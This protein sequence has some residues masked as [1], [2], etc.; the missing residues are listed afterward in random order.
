LILPARA[1]H[2]MTTGNSIGI[3][4]PVRRYFMGAD[5]HLSS[6]ERLRD[7]PETSFSARVVIGRRRAAAHA[8]PSGDRLW[9]GALAA[10][11]RSRAKAAARTA[12]APLHSAR[13]SATSDACTLLYRRCHRAG[14]TIHPRRPPFLPPR[15]QPVR[16]GERPHG[17]GEFR[18]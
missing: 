10:T 8:V 3:R 6:L 9:P 15:A 16:H 13:V 11:R 7:Y 5:C 18:P 12:I 2:L 17:W 4:L 1:F 14:G